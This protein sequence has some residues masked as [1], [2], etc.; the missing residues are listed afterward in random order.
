MSLNTDNEVSFD[1][2]VDALLRARV[3]GQAKLVGYLE[4]VF[5]EVMFEMKAVAQSWLPAPKA[6]VGQG[7]RRWAGGACSGCW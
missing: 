5:E 7:S 1:W 4:E 6:T 3:E 2:L